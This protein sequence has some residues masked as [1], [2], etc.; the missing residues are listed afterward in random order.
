[1]LSA[2]AP[3]LA[4]DELRAAIRGQGFAL[5]ESVFDRSLTARLREQLDA[6]RIR[7]GARFGLEALREIGQD[8]Y[9]SDLMA[10]GDAIEEIL[11]DDA[12][13]DVLAALLG[14][15]RLFIGQGIVL[16]PSQGRGSWPRCWHADMFEVSRAIAD[17]VFCFAVN[18][19]VF[20]D[21]IDAGNG[22]TCV[23]PGSQ[24][25]EALRITEQAEL[26]HLEFRAVAPAG[27]LLVIEGGTWHSAST[28]RSDRPRR[29]LKLLF[30][31]SWIR[32]QIDYATVT[33]ADVAARLTP[34]AR[35]LLGFA[36]SGE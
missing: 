12:L 23:L 5:L 11:D 15:A 26:E 21:D 33:P 14:D 13:H 8:G 22:P 9:V 17:P 18:C 27:S 1:M 6:A 16:D 36:N 34:R 29:V 30:T 4:A 24:R 3:A 32:P 20:I 2:R 28:N 31:R 7:E 19:L 35:R 10:I 25:L